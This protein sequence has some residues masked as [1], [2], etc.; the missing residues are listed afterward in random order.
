MA[1]AKTPSPIS[2]TFSHS[3]PFLQFLTFLIL[4]LLLINLYHTP[5]PSAMASSE[6]IKSSTM[7]TT[8]LHPQ[9][10]MNS[11]SSSKETQREF[12]VEAHDVPSGPNPISN[13]WGLHGFHCIPLVVTKLGRQGQQ[14]S[15]EEEIRTECEAHRVSSG[16]RS[17][18]PKTVRGQSATFWKII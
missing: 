18:T 6:P 11:H 13:R 10:T 15:K 2:E 3:H 14:Q 4:L 16:V 5:N 7:S 17:V 1:E 8:N 9:K 12:G